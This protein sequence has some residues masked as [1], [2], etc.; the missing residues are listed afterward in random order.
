MNT[1]STA[2]PLPTSTSHLR[3]PS[4][5]VWSLMMVRRR[6]RRAGLEL[7]AQ[8]L[9]QVGH[10]VEIRRA[11][12]VDPALQLLGAE[13]LLPQLGAVSDELRGIEVQQVGESCHR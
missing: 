5:D 13:R 1:V 6:D 8:R 7:F 2:L 3:V 9:G 4:L 12:L 10:V 11:E